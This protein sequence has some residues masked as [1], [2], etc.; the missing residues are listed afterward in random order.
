M[1]MRIRSQ[2]T[3]EQRR[4]LRTVLAR[5]ERPEE[6]LGVV[7]ACLP[8]GFE[9]A[10]V[11]CN[12]QSVHPDRFVM[13]VRV[14]SAAGGERCCALKIYSDDFGEEM[15]LLAQKLA[16]RHPSNHNGLC[17]PQQYVREQHALVFPWVDGV[18][19]SEIVDERKPD[20]LRRAA[21]LAADFHRMPLT[22][23]PTLTSE[24]VVA[25]ALDRGGRLC[26]DWPSLVATVRPLLGLLQEVATELEPARP[27][28]IHGDMAAGQF[29]W[30]G[31]RLGLLGMGTA[32]LLDPAYHVR[33]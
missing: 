14:R 8:P 9:P 6:A 26:H 28:V 20:L 12:L 21:A 11:V 15:W 17:L 7:R 27:A 13:Q 4:E 1:S 3:R 19:L 5:F 16:E 32:S 18:R 25:E 24:M 33:H 30:T 2:A 29:V 23:L 22:D 31:D 10:S